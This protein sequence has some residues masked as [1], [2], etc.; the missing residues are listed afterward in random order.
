MTA[1]LAPALLLPTGDPTPVEKAV[2]EGIVGDFDPETLLWIIFH[3]PDGGARVWYAWTTGG[4]PL[5]E[6][7]D[8]HALAAGYD[9]SDWLHI[10][11]RHRTDHHR[12]RVETQAHPLRPIEADL[13]NGVR[14]PE[15]LRDKLRRLL[16]YARETNGQ[17]PRPDA[18]VPRWMGVGP[19]LLRAKD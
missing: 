1:T 6:H 16:D 14:A 15:E 2:V 9:A 10:T 7:I 4:V 19:T 8:Q 17:P 3:R 18:V 12:G 13:R 5:G 11:G